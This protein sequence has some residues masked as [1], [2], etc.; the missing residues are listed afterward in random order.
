VN[1][2]QVVERQK[3]F[4]KTKKELQKVL[5]KKLSNLELESELH[6]VDIES[7]AGIKPVSL[8]LITL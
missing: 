2:Q 4:K 8:D 6:L 3:M 1:K 7:S 5:G